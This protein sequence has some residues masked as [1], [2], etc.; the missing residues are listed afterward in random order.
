MLETSTLLKWRSRREFGGLSMYP[1]R[2]VPDWITTI[3][4]S[5]SKA[6]IGF[7]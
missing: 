7:S 5:L 3:E 2:D 1:P 4:D 6:I